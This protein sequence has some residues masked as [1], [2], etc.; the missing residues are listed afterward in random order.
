MPGIAVGEA[1]GMVE[2]GR[3]TSVILRSKQED[4][5]T[6]DTERTE[7]PLDEDPFKIGVL[8]N[9]NVQRRAGGIERFNV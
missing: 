1:E 2:I 9:P 5:T 4:S 6:E 3:V 7:E 8:I